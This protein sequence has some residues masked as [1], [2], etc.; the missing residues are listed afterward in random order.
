MKSEPI[1]SFS[2]SATK[3]G[4]EKYLA[5]MQMFKSTNVK[6]DMD[7]QRKFNGFYRIRSS[8]KEF[9]ACYYNFLED[10][11]NNRDLKFDEIL[12]YFYKTLG[13]VEA[14]FSSKILATINPQMPIWD[15][16]VIG[17]LNLKA[18]YY[19]DKNRLAKIVNVYNEICNWYQTAEAQEKLQLFNHH[20]SNI[21][22]S[23]TKKIDF[24]LWQIR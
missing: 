4:I 23:D 2:P 13:R 8:S 18:P 12:Q 9:Y 15:K 6:E 7:F 3:I 21:N 11:K 24:V 5:I 10:N 1:K 16:F 20:F 14:S 19:S 22:I 17:N